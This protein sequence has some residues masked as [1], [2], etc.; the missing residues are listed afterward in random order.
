MT[1]LETFCHRVK[2]MFGKKTHWEKMLIIEKTRHILVGISG[3]ETT[4]KYQF[5]KSES[6][7]PRG[8]NA[9]SVVMQ[10]I[11]HAKIW[12]KFRN[13]KYIDINMFRG[14]IYS[15]KDH[16]IKNRLLKNIT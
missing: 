1:A 8:Y 6:S 4:E 15:K 12:A 13:E 10:L 5:L 11:I 16:F 9:F 2:N 14:F 3:Y 7:F